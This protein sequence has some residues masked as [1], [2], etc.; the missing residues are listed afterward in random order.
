LGFAFKYPNLVKAVV[1]GVVA[2][3]VVGVSVVAARV[4]L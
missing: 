3:L 1:G 2:G 4:V